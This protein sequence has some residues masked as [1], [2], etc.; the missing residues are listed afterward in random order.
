[1]YSL[2]IFIIFIT[3]IM[4]SYLC[5]NTIIFSSKT[6]LNRRLTRHISH[7]DKQK[8][9][10]SFLTWILRLFASQME[11]LLNI[12]TP[13]W[14][15][16][17]LEGKLLNSSGN[18]TI[19]KV[20]FIK[21][22]LP[23]LTLLFLFFLSLLGQEVNPLF[24]LLI[25]SLMFI[26][27]DSILNIGL[28]K[29]KE[30]IAQELPKFVEILSVILESGISFD[31]AISKICSR[32]EGHLYKEWNIYLQSLQ[33]GT[34]RYTGLQQMARRI[35][36]KEFDSIIRAIISGDRMGVSI[37]QTIQS[38]AE[39]LRLKEKQQYYEKAMKIPIKMLFPLVFFFFPP[40]F[41]VILGPGVINIFE[42][43]F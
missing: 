8:I 5:F 33:M 12:V 27:P 42:N 43:L 23:T 16:S 14:Y 26:L 21:V 15:K 6:R 40:I 10:K 7:M 36:I 30:E 2:L 28:K 24:S 25:V 13:K 20:L 34:P 1:M 38:Q 4:I 39:T 32:K 41:I 35:Q 17:K 37:V 11:K 19:F 22:L 29:K 9:N 31:Q 18:L 3:W